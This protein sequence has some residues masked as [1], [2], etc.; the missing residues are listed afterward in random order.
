[1]GPDARGHHEKQRVRSVNC[2]CDIAKPR[3]QLLAKRRVKFFCH[4][5]QIPQMGAVQKPIRPLHCLYQ[6]RSLR[7]GH[8]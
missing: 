7:G 4:W 5:L 8:K 1:M 3:T 2:A 6:N